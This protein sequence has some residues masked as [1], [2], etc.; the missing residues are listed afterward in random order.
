[1]KTN[2]FLSVEASVEFD[3]RHAIFLHGR[4]GTGAASH[5]LCQAEKNL[6]EHLLDKSIA[7][8]EQHADLF[9]Q[10]ANFYLKLG[11]AYK[12]AAAHA[13][14]EGLAVLTEVYTS[15]ADQALWEKLM[16]YVPH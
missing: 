1:M 2:S 15:P 13:A 8:R 5:L 16:T 14:L 3:I 9:L 10:I 12:N 11:S 6:Q 4:G 7:R